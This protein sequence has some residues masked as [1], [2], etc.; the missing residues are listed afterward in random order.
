MMPEKEL[1]IEK[2]IIIHCHSI[3]IHCLEPQTNDS[4]GSCDE[5]GYTTITINQ[6]KKIAE[7]YNDKNKTYKIREVCNNET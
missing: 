3:C 2:G 6:A 1:F 7:W 4:N 5:C